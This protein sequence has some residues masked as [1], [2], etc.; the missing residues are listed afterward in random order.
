M[1]MITLTV[2]THVATMRHWSRRLWSRGQGETTD[3]G[4]K[5]FRVYWDMSGARWGKNSCPW[6]WLFS[7]PLRVEAQGGRGGHRGSLPLV[8][9]TCALANFPINFPSLFVHYAGN[10]LES[11]LFHHHMFASTQNAV[12][13]ECYFIH[14]LTPCQG[15]RLTGWHFPSSPCLVSSAVARFRLTPISATAK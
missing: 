13:S 12:T 10:A 7:L 5:T 2:F 1:Q 6:H 15:P 11:T 3:W 14:S 4:N 8:P 9:S